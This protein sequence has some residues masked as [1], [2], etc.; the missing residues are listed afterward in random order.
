M[1]T[2]EVVVV[3]TMERRLGL[4]YLELDESAISD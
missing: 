1:K 4:G 2:I 3:S